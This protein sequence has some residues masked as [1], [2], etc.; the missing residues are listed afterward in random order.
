MATGF[1][2][3]FQFDAAISG[4]TPAG[5]HTNEAQASTPDDPSPF[6]SVALDLRRSTATVDVAQATRAAID[7]SVVPAAPLPGGTVTY[8]LR[9]GNTSGTTVDSMDA[10]DILPFDGDPRG[11]HFGAGSLTLTGLIPSGHGEV[12][13]VSTVGPAALDLLDGVTDGFVDPA[14]ASPPSPNPVLPSA[15][16]PCRFIDVGT[17]SC[18]G[19]T[20][21]TQVTALRIVGTGP[22]FLPSGSGPHPIGITFAVGAN[23]ANGDTFANSWLARFEGLTF[24]VFVPAATATVTGGATT[25]P[26]QPVDTTVPPTTVPEVVPVV[27]PAPVVDRPKDRRLRL[28]GAPIGQWAAFGVMALGL[29]G[30][31]TMAA[32]RRRREPLADDP[33]VSPAGFRAP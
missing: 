2:V 11:S 16:W 23:A 13:W 21:L 26:I 30:G 15:Q 18:T 17:T 14:S 22:G 25:P 19:V 9:Y 24:P 32:A 28:T 5:T 31:L 4:F 29:G 12:V 10:V 27:G 7:K 20:S 3:D 6:G 8:T 33:Q 1:N